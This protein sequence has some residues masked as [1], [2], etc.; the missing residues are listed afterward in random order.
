[1]KK[2]IIVFYTIMCLAFCGFTQELS[3]GFVAKE[4]V[5]WFREGIIYQIWLRSFTEAGSIAAAEERLPEIAQLGAGIIYMQPIMLQDTSRNKSYWSPRQQ[6]SAN[7]NPKNPYRIMDYYKIDPEYGTDADLKRFVN[8]AHSLGLKVILDVV[9]LHTGPSNP[10]TKDLSNYKLDSRGQL[11]FN[12]WNFPELNHKNEKLR[13]YLHANLEYWVKQ[14]DVDGFR[15]DVSGEV[16]VDFWEESRRRLEK[17]KPDIGMLAES[18]SPKEMLFGFDATYGFK[19]Y[20]EIKLVVEKGESA[21]KLAEAWTIQNQHFPKGTLFLRYSD[22][23]DQNRTDFIFGARGSRAVNV[24]N[25]LLDG[26]PF[27][28]NGQEIGDGSPFGLYTNW[29]ILWEAKHMPQKQELFRWYQSLIALRKKERVLHN[30]EVKWLQ[31]SDPA[32]IIAFTRSD[33]ED[34]ILTIINLSNRKA[35]TEIKLVQNECQ[36]AVYESVMIDFDYAADYNANVKEKST[37]GKNS[38][39]IN[40]IVKCE[41]EAFGYFVGKRKKSD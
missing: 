21:H 26:V 24:M 19:W 17:I 12:R 39:S 4:P 8:T 9:F 38:V 5:S 37:S 33:E 22:N 18:R 27:I 7:Q 25:F 13:E 29:P 41:L 11:A 2:I 1:M 36:G 3:G 6:A 32:S 10:L 23:H 28:Y 40:G 14:F 35:S 20:D 31:T 15:C 16:P 30:G 34:E